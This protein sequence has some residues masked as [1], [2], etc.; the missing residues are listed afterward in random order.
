MSSL[1]VLL[2]IVAV[3]GVAAWL[4]KS[5]LASGEPAMP[6]Y[7][8]K[9]LSEP[10]QALWRRLVKALPDHIVLAHMPA[11]RVLGVEP[12]HGAAQRGVEALS[13]DFVV[14]REDASVLAAIELDNPLRE[15]PAGIEAM[16]HAAGVPLVRWPADALPDE[17][18]IQAALRE[19][20]AG[21][22]DNVI[23]L[24]PPA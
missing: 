4:L 23:R 11:A 10:E 24:L 16:L 3:L 1:V 9:P 2:V 7:A 14:C 21:A 15:R 18:A 22:P 6:F 8:K 13:L 20:A 19:P 5:S 12:G 17:A